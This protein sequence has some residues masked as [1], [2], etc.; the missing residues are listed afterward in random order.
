MDA[1]FNF[2]KS[3][4]TNPVLGITFDDILLVPEYT[5]INSRG[6]CDVSTLL[7][8]NV[9]LKIPIVSSPMDSVTEYKMALEL[10][11]NGG[12]GIVH[13]YQ[14]IEDQAKT[15]RKIKKAENIFITDP[16]IVDEEE[17]VDTLISIS[18]YIEKR[19]FLVSSYKVD[20][21]K[22]PS[23]MREFKSS[24][25]KVSPGDHFELKGIITARDMRAA[26]KKGS[27]VKDVMTPR[28]KLTVFVQKAG[29][30]LESND[31]KELYRIMLDHRIE[32]LPLVDDKNII[33]GL[34]TEK[35][36]SKSLGVNT[37]NVDPKGKL[38]VGCAV[39]CRDD[40]LERADEL[41][42]A[43]ANVIIVDIAN[44][45]NVSNFKAIDELKSRF[46]GVD[47]IGGNVATAD[48]A[49]RHI[50]HGVDSLRVGLG[51]GSICSTRLVSGC[52]VPQVTALLDVLTEAD[53]H[54]IPVISDGGIRTSGAMAKALAVGASSVMLGSMLAGTEESPGLPFLKD[55]TFVK[56]H[57]GMAGFGAN[58]SKAERIKG[59]GSE[60]NSMSF[61]PEGVEGF[62]PYK[63]PLKANVHQMVMGIKSGMSYVG[64]KNLKE[65]R[66]MS[67]FTLTSISGIVEGG[68][69]VNKI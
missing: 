26:Q 10:A 42:N 8:R 7:S 24:V 52:G 67:H 57:R 48:G 38:Y 47:V 19:S 28:E 54:K 56:I 20:L 61:T 17:S 14:S 34:V 21:S 13:R 16:F 46:K 63:G 3:F 27:K 35:D 53:Q 58:M 36:I 18:D 32:K 2:F 45:H 51:N 40:Y 25:T 44:G 15:I 29:T 65:F 64:A 9:P 68:I 62:V 5:E 49:R 39:G 4:K 69:S 6:D 59:A 50:E 37:A 22:I 66:D 33:I 11:R 55:G 43:G 30:K 12:I 60:P 23:D 41:V 1:K 31:T